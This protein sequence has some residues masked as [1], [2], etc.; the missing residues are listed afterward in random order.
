MTDPDQIESWWLEESMLPDTLRWARLRQMSD[1]FEL[2]EA[3]GSRYRFATHD[4]AV[5]W[6]AD[7]GY[8]RYE[9]LCARSAIDRVQP[10]SAACDEELLPLLI[11]RRDDG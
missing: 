6:L 8:T 5:A 11:R 9:D 7:F 4:D 10:P 3:G 2:L 1:T